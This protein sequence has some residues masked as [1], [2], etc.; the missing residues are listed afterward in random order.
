MRDISSKI[1]SYDAMPCWA[2]LLIEVSLDVLRYILFLCICFERCCN[3][4]KC[5]VL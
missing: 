5:I 4:S 3:D 1:T 2:V